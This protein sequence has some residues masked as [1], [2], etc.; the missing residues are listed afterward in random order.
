MPEE[1]VVFNEKP[2]AD[3]LIAGRTTSSSTSVINWP[4]SSARSLGTA[5]ICTEKPSSK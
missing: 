2:S 4:Y 1:L 3:Y 5:L